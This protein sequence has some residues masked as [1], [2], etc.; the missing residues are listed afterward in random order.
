MAEAFARYDRALAI[1]PDLPQVHL[2]RALARLERGDF[3]RG[4][5]EYEWRLKCPQFA[6]PG[7]PQPPWDGRALEGRSILLY[8]DHGLGDAIQ[9][10]RYAPMVRARCGRVVV[11]CRDPLARLL[12]TC[13]GVGPRRHRGLA[14]SGLQRL[15]PAHEPA[16]AV[17]DGRGRAYQA[18]VPYL[19]ADP[20]LV[21]I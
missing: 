20:D 12:A 18:I 21:H 1:R 15:C 11:V 19:S 7:L 14:D 16:G 6:I 5:P 10:I 8:A 13:E 2:S 17:P 3:E 4:W 9:F